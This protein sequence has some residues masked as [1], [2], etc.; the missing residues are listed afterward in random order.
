VDI[1]F[2]LADLRAR[3]GNKSVLSAADIAQELGRTIN[4]VYSLN[5]RDDWPFPALQNST[6]PCASIYAVAEWLAG[7]AEP[8]ATKKIKTSEPVQTYEPKPR[9]RESL[10][11]Y[12]MTV[13]RQQDFLREYAAEIEAMILEDELSG[14]LE[15]GGKRTL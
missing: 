12:L 7:L 2:I 5:D 13:K 6:V 1:S 8:K 10:G 3:H 14:D 4:A 11:K 9:K 15:S